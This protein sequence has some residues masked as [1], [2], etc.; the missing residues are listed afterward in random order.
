MP[1]TFRFLALVL[2]ALLDPR[3]PASEEA[4]RRK[5]LIIS[6]DGTRPDALQ[7]ATAP[8]LKGLLEGAAY[9]FHAQTAGGAEDLPISGP[10]YS[11][12][13]S[14]AWCAKHR[15]C[16]NDFSSSRF[17]LYPIFFCRLR[18]ARPEV[19]IESIVRWAPLSPN[20]IT[21][22]D[23][24]LAPA[25]DAAAAEEGVRLLGETDPDVLF[26]H[27]E[28][29]D[30]TGHAHG[31]SPDSPEYLS[32]IETADGRVGQLLQALR[33]RPAFPREDWL[34][35]ALTDHGGLGMD[36]HA[37]VPECM[38]IFF[39]ENGAQVVGGELDPPPRIID[40]APTAMEFL[41]LATDPA[42]GLDG[43]SVGLV[44]VMPAP[45]QLPSD[46]DGDGR[47][48]IADIVCVLNALFSE[49]PDPLP[50]AS[51]GPA[52]GDLLLD[53]N[54]DGGLDISDAIHLLFYMF[55]AGPPPA[56]GTECRTY[57]GCPD[58]CAG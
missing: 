50:C 55:A 42:W 20:L 39:I 2:V 38:T 5:V 3:L 52:G 23:V 45:R 26:F 9:S 1:R 46:C 17:D 8:N 35:L 36:H 11:S 47:L 27:L 43:R 31:F 22:A 24:D 16:D 18:A 25:S 37:R 30:T 14:G 6:V 13:L 28:D 49:A 4:P 58:A 29:V 44:P 41:G 33:A 51:Q 10:G 32:A 34:I 57:E 48:D 56:G 53:S 12:M 40:V 21:C 54:G 19:V 15:V 7:A